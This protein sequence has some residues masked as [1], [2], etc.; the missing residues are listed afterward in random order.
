MA[1]KLI[2]ICIPVFNEQDNIEELHRRL[3]AVLA[4]ETSYHFEMIFTDNHSED[5]T[6][7]R[8]TSL[9]Q[10]DP[11][12][13]VI[14]FAKN[15]G[16]QK[17]IMFNFLNA[18]GDAAIQLDADMQDP[19]ELISEFLRFWEK[20]SKVVYGIRT[21][22]KENW[23]LQTVRR[24]FY[25][26]IN[27]I[28]E[29]TLPHDAGDFR[30]IDRCIIEE[31]RKVN[32]SQPYLRGLIA[33]MGFVQTGIPYA[34]EQRRA[35][36]SKFNLVRLFSLALDGILHHSVIPLRA[37]SLVG[38]LVS[39]VSLLGGLYYLVAKIFF[40]TDWPVGLASICILL[41]F[42]IGVNAVFLGI[43]G[44]YIGAIYKNV[45]KM[46][47]VIVEKTADAAVTRDTTVIS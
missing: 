45:K 16:F 18:K 35:G 20:G 13:R 8:L 11:R 5:Q 34:R 15:F 10:R 40:H 38:V 14:R 33:S 24:V 37:A 19:P 9:A 7:S 22:R 27:F 44:E 2:S 30:L 12:V 21:K 47:F 28:S 17:S 46:P 32:D 26:F 41:C 29:D 42:S 1:K 3:S 43:I 6:F 31:L 39:L 25:R 4:Q 36:K 23:L